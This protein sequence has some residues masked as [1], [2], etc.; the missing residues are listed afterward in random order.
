MSS[1]H[2]FGRDIGG[3]GIPHDGSDGGTVYGHAVAAHRVEG[4]G[5]NSGVL[6]G[7]QRALL[8]TPQGQG[9]HRRVYRGV[10]IC[11]A[12]PR[13]RFRHRHRAEQ[14]DCADDLPAHPLPEL[15]QAARRCAAYGGHG[16]GAAQEYHPLQPHLHQPSHHHHRLGDAGVLYHVHRVARDPRP[17]P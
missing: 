15:C 11:A 14:V 5:W 7:A 13:W 16:S 3:R 17:F 1:P 9:Y 12:H 4:S 6:L 8:H 10:R 2:S